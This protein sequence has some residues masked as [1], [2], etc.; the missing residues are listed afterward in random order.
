MYFRETIIYFHAAVPND[1]EETPGILATTEASCRAK[2]RKI[3]DQ[4]K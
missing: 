4:A 3:E 1:V 2:Q